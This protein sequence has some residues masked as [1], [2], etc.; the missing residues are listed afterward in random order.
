LKLKKELPYKKGD[1]SE[2]RKNLKIT[3]EGR[4]GGDAKQ[5]HLFV[6]RGKT[7]TGSWGLPNRGERKT[8]PP[9]GKPGKK[10]MVGWCKGARTSAQNTPER[11][12]GEIWGPNGGKRVSNGRVVCQQTATD[13]DSKPEPE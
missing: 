2:K 11:I 6:T 8:S 5:K 3:K 1:P 12:T 7:L 4:Q 10:G 9:R 13:F